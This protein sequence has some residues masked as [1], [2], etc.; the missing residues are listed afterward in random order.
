MGP[1]RLRNFIEEKAPCFADRETVRTINLVMR[2][3]DELMQEFL[4]AAF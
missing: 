3:R 4:K 1:H 2:A